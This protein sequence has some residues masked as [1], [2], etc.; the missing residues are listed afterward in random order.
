MNQQSL[1][2]S[3]EPEPR[4]TP[5][6]ALRTRAR[7]AESVVIDE[8]TPGAIYVELYSDERRRV[9]YKRWALP[10]M[11]SESNEY[12]RSSGWQWRPATSKTY[13]LRY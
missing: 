6:K 9:L 12:L 11:V 8:T 4:P 1:F 5:A 10:A 2:S 13:V 3:P 7:N